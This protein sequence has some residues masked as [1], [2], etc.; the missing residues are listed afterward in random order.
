M[1]QVLATVVV[2]DARS[3]DLRGIRREK[4]APYLK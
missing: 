3:N 4:S 1:V 2:K